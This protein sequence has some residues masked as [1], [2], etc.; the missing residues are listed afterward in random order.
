MLDDV[1]QPFGLLL[2]ASNTECIG[3]ILSQA[4]F[5][6]IPVLAPRRDK[7]SWAVLASS[8]T[9]ETVLL[10]E[11][12]I[13]PLPTVSTNLSL[14]LV[15]TIF[16]FMFKL[17]AL[18]N[19]RLEDMSKLAT[20]H[21]NNVA[22][23]ARSCST[24]ANMERMLL[25]YTTTLRTSTCLRATLAPGPATFPPTLTNMDH[26]FQQSRVRLALTQTNIRPYFP[27]SAGPRLLQPFF[28]WRPN[29][30]LTIMIYAE[31]HPKSD[32]LSNLGFPAPTE[33]FKRVSMLTT[34]DER[35]RALKQMLDTNSMMRGPGSEH[36]MLIMSRDYDDVDPLVPT[37]II[38]G[39]YSKKEITDTK[40]T[41]SQ[42]TLIHFRAT[43]KET[44]IALCKERLAYQLED[45]VGETRVTKSKK[46]TAFSTTEM[47]TNLDS[48]VSY[49][50]DVIS[51]PQCMFNCAHTQ[52]KS[53]PLLYNCIMTLF[54]FVTS[55]K[56]K[57]WFKDHAGKMPLFPTYIALLSDKLF[58]GFVKSA[59]NY[60]NQCA[61]E[62][63][64]V[65]NLDMDD[66]SRAIGTFYNT[67]KEIKKNVD[68]D[69]PWV[70]YPAFLLPFDAAPE[71]SIIKRVRTAPLTD[72]TSPPGAGGRGAG[73]GS[74]PG[75][76]GNA[77]RGGGRGAGRGGGVNTWGTGAG[78][79]TGSFGDTSGSR[80]HNNNGCYIL[81]GSM[82][83]PVRTLHSKVREQYCAKY[84][85]HGYFCRNPNCPFKHG[86]FNNYP[87]N[88]QAK[89]LAY[90]E[91]NKTM[92]LF[93]TNC[94]PT[95]T[96]LSDKRHLIA[97]SVQSPAPGEL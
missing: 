5:N 32:V 23:G 94:H 8:S 3:V 83:D 54:N 73:R 79:G 91:A 31:Y 76:D 49:L 27:A 86:W 25:P 39:I 96:L 7:P 13:D 46:R 29:T 62:E 64:V 63:G 16:P 40:S 57:D 26:V 80:I 84:S 89:Q 69:K 71:G 47:F 2:S 81:L 14:F 88:L 35:V 24:I 17:P 20:A 97:P 70:D 44:A 53:R 6:W 22:E 95:A 37:A 82:R 52:A 18:D 61:A 9:V 11:A 58:I 42:F 43:G 48:V 33:A 50:A 72:S 4:A 59:E 68:Y 85:A 1:G 60:T 15:P 87:A 93:P 75:R 28:P 56:T 38:T 65:T 19:L 66:L 74:S 67:V 51:A 30:L 41:S 10:T 12:G 45:A 90:V 55:K 77:G 36:N 78:F 21:G 34:K 92:V